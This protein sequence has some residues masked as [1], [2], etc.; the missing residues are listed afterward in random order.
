MPSE[1]ICEQ[2]AMVKLAVNFR[3]AMM[4]ILCVS[5]EKYIEAHS[6]P[7]KSCVHARMV[8]CW[9]RSRVIRSSTT[10]VADGKSHVYAPS[11]AVVKRWP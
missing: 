10:S 6:R 5:A 7:T 4:V 1:L 2:P 8:E 9:E 11:G 3:L